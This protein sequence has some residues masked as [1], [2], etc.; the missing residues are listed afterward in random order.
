MSELT[1][2]AVLALVALVSVMLWAV[3]GLFFWIPLLL[4]ITSVFS[5]KV[6][7]AAITG[8]SDMSAQ[9]IYLESAATM[10]PTGFRIIIEALYGTQ[11]PSG[12]LPRFTFLEFLIQTFFSIVVWLIS[13][14][15][16][17]IQSAAPLVI[18]AKEYIFQLPQYVN[19]I[20]EW[21]FGLPG[22]W[23]KLPL[24]LVTY[25]GILIAPDIAKAIRESDS[26]SS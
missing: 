19:S 5:A 17:G 8:S 6:M 26:K 15:L 16:A 12:L 24:L 11:A 1:L 3:I 18:L 23:W 22:L 10:Y 20:T 4:R 2:K 14:H 13:I 7:Y 9:K 25:F 21:L